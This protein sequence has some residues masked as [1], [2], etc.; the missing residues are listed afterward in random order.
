MFAHVQKTIA[1]NFGKAIR[2]HAKSYFSEMFES[3]AYDLHHF[4][5]FGVGLK[6]AK[7][8]F[9]LVPIYFGKLPRLNWLVR[10][11]IHMV[12]VNPSTP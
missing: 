10:G 7:F 5:N 8:Q 11:I 12:R 9:N 2:N 1:C 3:Y 6:M 4:A